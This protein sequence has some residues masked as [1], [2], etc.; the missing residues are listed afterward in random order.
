MLSVN[1]L[2]STL[3]PEQLVELLLGG[4]IQQVSNISFTGSNASAGTFSGGTSIFGFEDG[5]ILSTGSIQNIIGPNTMENISYSNFLPGD[6]DLDSLVTPYNTFDATVLEFDF[7]PIT[8][9]IIFQYQFASDEYNEWVNSE[10]NDV[11]AFFLNGQNIA[12]IPGTTT[13]V[14]INNVNLDNNAIYYI[15]NDLASGAPRDTEMDGM[16]V[17]LTAKA[18]VAPFEINH[19][20]LAIADTSDYI[21]DSN[22]L[23]KAG[24]FVSDTEPPVLTVPPDITVIATGDK[25]YVDIGIATAT[26][27]LSKP[28]DIVIINDAPEDGYPVGTTVVTWTATDQ[29]GNTATATQNVT[30]NPAIKVIAIDIKPGSYPNSINLKNNGNVPV[31][32]LGS[33]SFYVSTID[34]STVTFA[35]AKALNIGQGLEDVNGDGYMDKVFHFK[36]SELNLTNSSTEAS[37]EGKT[38]AGEN[39]KGSDSVRIVQ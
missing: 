29:S 34:S 35:N 11:F 38:L 31:A 24:S 23:I 30:V 16:T 20:K 19:I 22:V 21:Y 14:S 5:V 39:F 4:G 10:Y 18:E 26:D 33:E 37:L 32:V 17:T 36:T 27:N 28:E 15:N 6:S 7:T 9:E 12:L 25:T 3:T 8:N 13:P 2:S 1:E